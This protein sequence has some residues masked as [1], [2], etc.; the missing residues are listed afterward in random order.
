[1]VTNVVGAMIGAIKNNNNRHKQSFADEIL[2]QVF[3]CE[4]CEI[5]LEHL[6][7]RTPPHD[8][9]VRRCSVKKIL[10]R[11]QN[12]KTLN[13]RYALFYILV[14][15]YAICEIYFGNLLYIFEKKTFCRLIGLKL[16]SD[17]LCLGDSSNRTSRSGVF[18]RKGVLRNFVKFT[19]I[20]LCRSIFFRSIFF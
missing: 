3:S 13:N 15:I 12:C 11:D 5:F 1:M 17:K 2:A 9:F 20:H 18:C 19:V 10:I 6:F 4:F 16:L 14:M 8:C 7:Y